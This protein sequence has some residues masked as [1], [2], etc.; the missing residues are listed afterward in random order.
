MH[1]AHPNMQ[2]YLADL[3]QRVGLPVNYRRYASRYAEV[4]PFRPEIELW[5]PCTGAPTPFHLPHQGTVRDLVLVW[6]LPQQGE[7]IEFEHDGN[8]FPVAA[9]TGRKVQLVFDL[10]A[11]FENPGE[12]QPGQVLDTVLEP[13]LHKAAAFV[14]AYDFSAER[15]RFVAWNVNGLDAQVAAWRGQ[16]RD[17]DYELDRIFTMTANLVRKNLQIKELVAMAGT[18]TKA[19]LTKRAGDEFGELRKMV[20]DVVESF[21]VED[22]QLAVRLAP[23]T[24]EYDGVDYEMGRYTLTVGNDTVRIYCDRGLRYPHPHVSSDGVPCWGNLGPSMARLLGE[25]QYA[26]LVA[27]IVTFLHSYNERDAYRSIEHWDPDYDE[28]A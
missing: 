25:R 9:V 20:P 27:A 22:G 6:S 11:L 19:E 1:I 3:E 7:R 4:L 17:N 28:D 14:R 12:L 5:G 8:V 16:L 15:T 26:G 23:L 2:P 24:L 10:E 21:D 18:T 13:A